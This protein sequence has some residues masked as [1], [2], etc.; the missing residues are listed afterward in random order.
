MANFEQMQ[1]AMVQV[2][3]QAATVVVRAMREADPS[4]KPN[5]R[6]SI[7]EYTTEQDKLD[8]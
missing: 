4:A 5:T 3:T 1:A 7:P 6:K 2:A 8:Q